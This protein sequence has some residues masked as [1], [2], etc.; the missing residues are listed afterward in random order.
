LEQDILNEKL[1][2]QEYLTNLLNEYAYNYYVLEKPIV[3][4]YDYDV[5]Y[6]ELVLLEQ[7]TN[8]ILPS[9]PTQRVGGAILKGFKKVEHA[10]RLYSLNKCNDQSGLEKF[11]QDVK[12]VNNKANFVVEYKFDG[13]RIIAKYK[14]GVLL[15]ASTRGN[16][17]VGEDVTQQV[18]TIKSVP[19]TIDYKGDLTVAGEGVITIENLNK[20][21]KTAQEKLKNARNAVAGAIRNL[22]PKIT[23]SRNLD[24]VFYDVVSIE[25]ETLLKTQEDVFN[26]LKQNKFLTG[27]LFEVCSTTQQIEQIIERIDKVK[28]KLNILI[29]GLVIKLNDL[30][31]REELGFTAKFPKWAI[32]YKFAPQELTSTLKDVLWN[33]GRTGKVTPIAVIDPIELAGATVT[34]ATLNNCEDIQRKNVKLNSLVFVRRSNE[35]IPEILGLAQEGENA[36]PIIPPTHCPS[37]G[38]ELVKIGPNLFCNN[39]NCKDRVIARFSHFVARNCMNI[40]GLSIKNLTT[41]YENCGVKSLPDLYNLKTEDLQ[42]LEGFKDKKIN[43]LLLGIEKSKTCNLNNFIDAL[44]IDGVGE[45]TA[46]DLAKKFKT[47]NNIKNAKIEDLIFMQDVGEVIAQNIYNY[48]NDPNNLKEIEDL[49]S[50]GVKIKQQEEVAINTNSPFYNKKVVLTGSLQ[51]YKRS[52]ATAIIE[53]LGGEVVGSVSKNTDIVLVGVDAGSKLQ[54]AQDLNIKIISEQEF[55]DMIAN[56]K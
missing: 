46:K 32:A 31:L 28:A 20:Y 27:K 56:A 22:D 54:K 25:D 47:L 55:K 19:L 13:L 3:S 26:F 29:D 21:N 12:S 44:G 53:S 36:K 38:N 33:V 41:L 17:L 52:E 45:K 7:T 6:D 34:R 48:F 8:T 10:V 43:N 37:C 16:G 9:S 30:K 39:K 5:L 50:L 14:N 51:D 1:K 18:K 35:V 15:Q 4:D 40:E 49:I 42:N 23:A 2:R 24:V 11:I